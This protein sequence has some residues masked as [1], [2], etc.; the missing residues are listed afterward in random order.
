MMEDQDLIEV[1]L[2]NGR[3]LQYPAAMPEEQIM[4]HAQ[5]RWAKDP[6]NQT[7]GPI[8]PSVGFKDGL[9]SPQGANP[10]STVIPELG[11]ILGSGV[12]SGLAAASPLGQAFGKG[13]K[14]GYGRNVT[15]D[16]GAFDDFITGSSRKGWADPRGNP[17][18]YADEFTDD[19]VNATRGRIR[20]G[21]DKVQRRKPGAK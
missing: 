20:E 21:L 10:A 18:E 13:F 3:V 11:M 17:L 1:E 6:D 7:I 19:A 12:L 2:P 5:M 4:A 16:P 14:R 8:P 9:R 15:K